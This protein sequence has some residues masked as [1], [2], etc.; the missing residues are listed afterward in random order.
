VFNDANADGVKAALGEPG[1]ASWA[2]YI[3]ANENGSRDAGELTDVTDAAGAYSLPVTVLRSTTVHVRDVVQANWRPT[4][5]A[6]GDQAV[7]VLTNNSSVAGVDFGNTQRALVTGTVFND[8]NGNGRLD[9]FERGLSGWTVFA[10]NDNDGVRDPRTEPGATTDASGDY[11]LDLPAGA[12]TIRQVLESGWL[13][14]APAGGA[15]AVTLAAGQVVGG[16]NFGDVLATRDLLGAGFAVVSESQPVR[17]DA[18][19]D[20]QYGVHNDGTADS[21]NFVVGFY[22]SD[23]A[24]ITTADRLLS[25]KGM[26]VPAHGTTSGADTLTL[27]A[28]DPYRTDNEYYVGMIVDVGGAVTETDETNN[29]GLG[30]LIDEFPIRSE[31]D[32]PRPT[33]G[34]TVVARPVTVGDTVAGTLGDEWIGGCDQDVYRFNATAG[35]KLALSLAG[36]AD[37]GLLRLYNASWSLV[38]SGVDTVNYTV[39]TAATYYAVVS[40]AG[41]GATNPRTLAN[42]TSGAGGAYTLAVGADNMDLDATGFVRHE[43]DPPAPVHVELYL[44]VTHFNPFSGDTI[45][46]FDVSFYLSDAPSVAA[47]SRLLTTV[48]LTYSDY[49][50]EVGVRQGY[51]VALDL[52]LPAAD[53]FLTDNQYSLGVVADGGGE[54]AEGSEGNNVQWFAL[55]RS[56]NDLPAPADGHQVR[57]GGLA[58]GF[59]ASR[60]IGDEWVGPY[61]QDIFQGIATAN[62]TIDFDLDRAPGST[63]DA[64]LRLYDADWN[65]LDSS[66]NAA[67]PDETVGVDPFVRHNFPTGGRYYAVVSGAGNHTSDPRLLTGRSASSTGAYTLSAQTNPAGPVTGVIFDDGNRNGTRDAGEAPL[68]GWAVYALPAANSPF[69]DSYPH[70]TTDPDGAF[71]LTGLRPGTYY[72]RPR[73]QDGWMQTA[74]APGADP[75]SVGTAQPAGPFQFGELKLASVAGTVYD[76][77]NEN[78]ARDAGES[79]LAGRTVY[80]DLNHNGVRDL[81]TVNF[82]FGGTPAYATD[83]FAVQVPD[84]GDVEVADVNVAMAV[85]GD[86]Q[87]W[88]QGP[89]DSVLL[90]SFSGSAFTF[91]GTFDDE[92]AFVVPPF[93][94]AGPVRPE[95]P[96]G[97]FDHTRPVG[98]WSLLLLVPP[99]FLVRPFLQS[100]SL[101]LTLSE[102]FETTAADGQYTFR[103]VVPGNYAVRAEDEPDRLPTSPTGADHTLAE[104]Q[105][106]TGQDFGRRPRRLRVVA[107]HVFYN[108]SA[109]DGR[110]AAAGEADDGAIAPDKVLL[111]AVQAPGAA[112]VTGYARGINGVMVDV[113]ELL[114]PPTMAD[115]SFKVPSGFNPSVWLDAPAPTGFAVRDLAG[116]DHLRR[117]T[118]TWPDSLLRN[119]WL[120]VGLLANAATRRAAPDLSYVG[121]LVGESGAGRVTRVDGADLLATRGAMHRGRAG[122]ESAFDFNRDGIVNVRDE[123]LVRSAIGNALPTFAAPAAAPQGYARLSRG[124]PAPRRGWTDAILSDE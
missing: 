108:N 98:T 111:P 29:A 39:P 66:D 92:A 14:T 20:V 117:V 93:G 18:H 53:P 8:V 103:D 54:L 44:E 82:P 84:Q 123:A 74:P 7:I 86:A 77:A 56:E 96:L 6:G 61:D 60:A 22:L 27:P 104:G 97:A 23:D 107:R 26:S 59:S 2:V 124:A 110:S 88:L 87:I 25:V 46:P 38:G 47:N 34:S 67:A 17:A 24:T 100:A 81:L 13:Q 28:A 65:L 50:I 105:A 122:V 48:R 12:R 76:D 115:F 51:P 3:D 106:E 94:G 15:Y 63:L 91:N 80:L 75:V 37:G 58:V 70:A 73:Q 16:R 19:V 119:T 41:N 1:L 30:G 113:A 10:D 40:A 49:R 68:G 114:T 36:L 89:G 116:S 62:E 33:D 102:P 118:F 55:V 57:A 95:S 43:G 71:V 64:Y 109:F 35:H 31:A 112:N 78:G 11:A 45:P 32:L 21:G 83:P 99:N 9:L 5:P 69:A 90:K 72:L 120:Q 79:G 85:S 42:R 52:N 121:N 4:A 101:Q